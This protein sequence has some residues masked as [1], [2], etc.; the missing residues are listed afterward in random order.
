MNLLSSVLGFFVLAKVICCAD[1]SFVQNY[2]VTWGFDHVVSLDQREIRLSM[3]NTSGAGFESRLGYGSG[4]FH[5]KIKIP[6]KDSAGV[7]TAFYLSSKGDNHDELD[8]EFLGNAEGKPFALQTNVYVNGV[9]N[10]EQ[11]MSLWFDPSAGF[12]D[13]SIL[14]NQHQIVFYV[15]EIP[16]RVF[17]NNTKLGVGY[18]ALRP[19]QIEA[20]LWDG[21]SWATEGGKRKV[22]WRRAPFRAY[23]RGF[24]INNACSVQGR[25]DN[26]SP[27]FSPKFWWNSQKYWELD[28]SKRRAYEI[29]KNRFLVY[30]YCDDISRSPPECP[31]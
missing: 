21:S 4:Y 12:H 11:K 14:W 25:T 9:G 18:P 1:V 22:D 30:D 24:D 19:M 29:V 31:Q 15:D 20:S 26:L 6:K 17:K 13:Y 27:C 8:F 16:I 5:M 10:R 3:D 7:V 23:F 2:K 28:D